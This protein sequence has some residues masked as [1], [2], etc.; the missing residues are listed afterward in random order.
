MQMAALNKPSLCAT[1]FLSL[2]SLLSCSSCSNTLKSTSVSPDG[3][4]KVNVYHRNCGAT[5]DYS[6]IVNLQRTSDRFDSD[7]GVLFIAKGQYGP[8]VT[9]TGPR[10]LLITCTACS[11]T[12]VFREVVALGDIDVTYTIGPSQ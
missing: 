8:S 2:V 10:A 4:L 11:R 12:N 6:S 5:T 9:W 3:Q 7:D 1:L